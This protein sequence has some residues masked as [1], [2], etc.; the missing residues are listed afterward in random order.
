MAGCGAHSTKQVL[1]NILDAEKAG[2]DYA[3]VLPS[4]YFGKATTPAVV[5]KFFVDVAA[6]SPLPVVIYNFPG[7]CNGVDLEA[8]AIA[9]IA[10]ENKNIVG[11]KLTCGSVGKITR[12]GALLP[13]STF[14]TFGGQ[15][16]FLMGGLTAGS[17]GCIA[18]FAN[19]APKTI[20]KVYGL[21]KEG[22]MAEALKL[23]QEAAVAE[24]VTRQSIAATKF[25]AAI[26]S[27]KEAGIQ[28][29]VEKMAPRTPYEP[30]TDGVMKAVE[31]AVKRLQDFE[32]TM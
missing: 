4:A 26:T 31:G 9:E 1:E 16:D 21:Y 8:A 17:A 30:P 20:V 13:P 27:A 23:H 6:A 32:T 12:L 25:A 3:L 5:K 18:A 14:A 22:K 11:V 29:A 24:G 19:V 10:N 7:V 15:S 2:A 28:S